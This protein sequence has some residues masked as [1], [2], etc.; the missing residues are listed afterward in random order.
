MKQTIKYLFAVCF[1]ASCP[2]AHAQ[3]DS[4]KEFIESAKVIVEALDDVSELTIKHSNAIGP[5]KESVSE[6]QNQVENLG[7]SLERLAEKLNA[8]EERIAKLES[9]LPSDRPQ[10]DGDYIPATSWEE[11]VNLVK[12]R[13]PVRVDRPIDVTSDAILESP[14][15]IKF[16]PRGALRMTK[17][18]VRFNLPLINE[19][20]HQIFVDYAVAT[21]YPNRWNGR[22]QS[23]LGHFGY[24]NVRD[25]RWW[26]LASEVSAQRV[27]RRQ[28]DLNVKAIEAAALSL[29][30]SH[31]PVTVKLPSGQ[32]AISRTVRLDGLRAT[33]Q[34]NG[35]AMSSTKLWCNSLKWKFDTTH[36]IVTEDFPE[37]STPVV[38]IGYERQPSGGNPDEGFMSG[39]RQLS[40]ICPL[41]PDGRVSG[42][43]WV[44]GLQ[45]GSEI[46]DVHVSG[47]SG[48][49]IGGPRFQ[50]LELNGEPQPYYTQLNGFKGRKWWIFGP[51]RNF[52][53]VIGV[54]LGGVTYDINTV[55][56]DHGR[57]AQGV[58]TRPAVIAGARECGSLS[59]FHIEM[60]PAEGADG[61]GVL[62]PLDHSVLQRMNLT[63][64]SYLPSK[65][66]R[67]SVK[68]RA[69][70]IEAQRG[71]V[72][73]R[74]IFC[75]GSEK[76]GRAIED[77][78]RAKVSSGFHSPTASSY[79]A[80]YDRQHEVSGYVVITTDPSLK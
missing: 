37:G 51:N 43:M 33:L 35:T 45:E 79:V 29:S 69:V 26:G 40:I 8:A 34:G 58:Q 44:S 68:H 53:D 14:R 47:H 65:P 9:A 48:M 61:V 66:H 19:D 78:F 46:V 36:K 67:D 23:V 42:I 13:N 11:L 70:K 24:H 22:G 56:I 75:A 2:F 77:V 50:R 25:A 6:T 3:E 63:A 64:I 1:L 5:L 21:N 7:S 15:A 72:S 71:G 32:I 20:N 54:S 60:S 10:A 76:F 52:N 27:P 62:V 12:G 30:G 55:T 80:S 73:C 18:M 4:Y 38:E 57:N 39:V 31:I 16:G 74:S 41:N 49:A 28:A 17:R 59:N